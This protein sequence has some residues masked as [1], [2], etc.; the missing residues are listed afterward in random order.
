[1]METINV[2]QVSGAYDRLMAAV[3]VVML[4][5]L[6]SR[7]S[8]VA[9]IAPAGK[10]PFTRLLE[11]RLRFDRIVIADRDD[12]ALEYQQSLVDNSENEFRRLSIEE[13]DYT[14]KFQFVLNPFGLQH[15]FETAP[16]F[17]RAARQLCSS[18]A[19]MI[20]LDWGITRYPPAFSNLPGIREEIDYSTSNRL[21]SFERSD[22]WQLALQREF[23]FFIR[24]TV[25]DIASLLS[26]G[27]QH[28]LRAHSNGV[29]H[30]DVGSSVLYRLYSSI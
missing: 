9:L 1:M 21:D 29:E 11:R 3:G 8:G 6:S 17:G 24:H 16:V 27:N 26:P 7:S 20:T 15:F 4:N 23:K 14:D 5:D 25:D 28:V 10:T 12:E 22:G 19:N 2:G 13:L 30:I 18:D